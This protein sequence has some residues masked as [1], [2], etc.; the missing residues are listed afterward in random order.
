MIVRAVKRA[1]YRPRGVLRERSFFLR[2]IDVFTID[3]RIWPAIFRPF[4]RK[5]AGLSKVHI[6]RPQIFWAETNFFI[7]PIL[8]YFFR[9]LMWNVVGKSGDI[10]A[11]VLKIS[12]YVSANVLWKYV[13]FEGVFSF[14]ILLSA[15][16]Q[17]RDFQEKFAIFLKLFCACPKQLFR[18]NNSSLKKSF[19]S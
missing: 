6:T 14:L 1:F 17:E 9:T 2:K 4:A 10:F 13:F 12:T 11:V 8:L 7:K 19:F 3:C 16:G 18:E 15:F 5:L